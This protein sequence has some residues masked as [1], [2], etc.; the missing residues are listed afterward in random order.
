MV[1]NNLLRIN[2][3]LGTALPTPETEEDAENLYH[4]WLNYLALRGED[5]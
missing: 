1:E 2:R 3:A 4:Q 5:L